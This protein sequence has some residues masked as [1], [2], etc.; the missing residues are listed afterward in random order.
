MMK[1]IRTLLLIA[2]LT[3]VGNA[4]ADELTVGEVVIKKG[5]TKTV[6]IVLNNT[7]KQYIA[8]E[9]SLSLPDGISIK[10]DEDELFMAKINEERSN[11]HILDVNETSVKGVYHFL[12]YS[13]S[14]KPFKGNSGELIQITVCCDDKADNGSFEASVEEIIFSDQDKV[15]ED[16]DDFSFGVNIVILGDVN[17]DGRVTPADAIM[18]LYHYFNVAQSGFNVNAADMNGD[19][20]ITPAD[21]IEALY[22]YF[23]SAGGNNARQSKPTGEPE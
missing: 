23:N 22:K 7:D 9:F 12:G 3:M 8:F 5:E 16:F 6:S 14:N 4:L 11:N 10:T 2:L 17:G 13:N 20:S 18:I 15:E 19:G 1:N 21:A